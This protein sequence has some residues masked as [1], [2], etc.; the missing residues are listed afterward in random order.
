MDIWLPTFLYRLKPVLYTIFAVLLINLLP[1][2]VV[3]LVAMGLVGFSV[4]ICWMR[5]HWG[6]AA[7]LK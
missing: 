2:I 5:L 4:W 6:N 3:T 7:E 1:G